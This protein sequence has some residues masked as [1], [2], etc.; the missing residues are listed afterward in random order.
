MIHGFRWK[1]VKAFPLHT[2]A[3]SSVYCD[4]YIS[5]GAKRA[6]FLA[7]ERSITGTSTKVLTLS[8]TATLL[9]PW[10]E[11]G[12]LHLWFWSLGPRPQLLILIERPISHEWCDFAC[13]FSACQLFCISIKWKQLM[14]LERCRR[15]GRVLEGH[16]SFVILSFKINC[17]IQRAKA[18]CT[19]VNSERERW[20]WCETRRLWMKKPP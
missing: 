13:C 8:S 20:W 15:W 3:P 16:L 7:L 17:W 4:L 5:K 10:T 6:S 11:H 2:V 14:G 18:G 9:I 1:T 12:N 19:L